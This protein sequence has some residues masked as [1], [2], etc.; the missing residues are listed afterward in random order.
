MRKSKWILLVGAAVLVLGACAGS[1]VAGGG[2]TRARGSSTAKASFGFDITC[3]GGFLT[4]PWVY[5]DKSPGT[6]G[7]LHSLTTKSVDVGGTLTAADELVCGA[8][9]SPPASGAWLLPYRP[10][11]GACKSSCTGI[12]HVVAHDNNTGGKAL[13]KL[14]FM[15][16]HLVGGYYDLYSN[17]PNPL[18]G[19]NLTITPTVI[20]T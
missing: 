9:T 12:A 8:P 4:G 14:D 1:E 16:I 15:G 7:F 2:F 19:G 13:A 20:T 3:N 17:G 11:G 18:L 10:Q 6:T 5:H